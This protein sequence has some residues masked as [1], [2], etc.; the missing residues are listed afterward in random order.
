[1]KISEV[2]GPLPCREEEYANIYD[3]IS[4]KLLD[5]CG[6][7]M[8][9]SGVPG[10]GKTATIYSVVQELRQA[11][12]TKQI[13]KFKFIE[14][15][16][17]RLTE[18]SQAYV[19]ILKQLTGEKAAAERSASILN[20]YFNSNQ[21]YATIVLVDELDLLWTRKQH[22]MYNL[23]DW[24]NARYSRLIVLAVANTMDLPE[25]TM[26]NRVS[27][28]LG[29]TR[30]TFQPYSFNQLERIIRAR[31]ANLEEIFSPD[32]IQ[33]VARK[34]AA[35]SGDVRR[36]LDICR[37][38]VEIV[39]QQLDKGQDLD[40]SSDAKVEMKHVATAI[41]EMFS[42]PKI[43]AIR[44]A[45]VHEQLFLRAVIVSFRLSG[46]EETVF[47]EVYEQYVSIC[48]TEGIMVCSPSEVLKLCQR[49]G[50]CKLL[51][52]EPGCAQLAKIRLNV[53]Q[54]DVS[55]AVQSAMQS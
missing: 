2:V 22:V 36:T 55:Y 13:P 9:I 46:V 5:K 21:K 32:A 49:L 47:K 33:F 6:G 24:P 4:S 35:V 15:N 3:F 23:F 18:P 40:N 41:S 14:I 44:N 34:V 52:V 25:R 28:R 1:L 43:A 51:L 50:S 20:T 45:S 42:S 27:S 10:T 30:L 29:L 8:Y 38:A 53:S 17:M 16:G 48:R 39:N 7:C 11:V 26:I 31:L 12:Q 19:E 54:D 37:R